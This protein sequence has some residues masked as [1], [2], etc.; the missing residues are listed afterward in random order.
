MIRHSESVNNEELAQRAELKRKVEEATFEQV[1]LDLV[2]DMKKLR[3][4]YADLSKVKANWAHRVTS[5]KRGRHQRG[6]TA[7]TAY[8]DQFLGVRTADQISQIIL[9]AAA[10]KVVLSKKADGKTCGP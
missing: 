2:S 4:Y 3:T 7:V 1:D 9:E 5:H 10:Q 6:L 8:M